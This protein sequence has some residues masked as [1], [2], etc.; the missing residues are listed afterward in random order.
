MDTQNLLLLTL[1]VALL[2]IG[3]KIA[4]LVS[5]SRTERVRGGNKA[6]WGAVILLIGL[7][8]SVAWF[9]LGRDPADGAAG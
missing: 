1:P 8:G 7:F 6:V 2:E 3:L 9:V 4:A 5:L